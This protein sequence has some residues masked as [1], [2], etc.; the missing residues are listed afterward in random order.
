[1]R[2]LIVVALISLGALSAGGGFIRYASLD[3]ADGSGR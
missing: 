3:W 2:K 1:M